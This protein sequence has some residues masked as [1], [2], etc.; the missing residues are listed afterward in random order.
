MFDATTARARC[1]QALNLDGRLGE[2][3]YLLSVAAFEA[4][5]A[6]EA[7]A[8]CR[9]ALEQELTS[10]QRERLLGSEALLRRREPAVRES[11]EG[12]DRIPRPLRARRAS[13]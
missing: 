9:R 4:G 10:A 8:A 12:M 13:E 2:A 6:D 7:R 3:W 1:R 5:L 11:A